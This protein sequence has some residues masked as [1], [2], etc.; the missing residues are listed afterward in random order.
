MPLRVAQTAKLMAGVLALPAVVAA[1][2]L[3]GIEGYRVLRPD[4][5]AFDTEVPLVSLAQAITECCRVEDAYAFISAGQDPNEPIT[6]DDRE[7]TGGGSITVS[8]LMLAVAAGNGS[9][10]QMLISFGA[11]PGLPQNRLLGC[12]AQESGQ[13][14]M[15]TIIA[16][17]AGER[18]QTD[19]PNRSSNDPRPL[20]RWVLDEAAAA[21]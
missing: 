14:E 20:L 13:T 8:P 9:V 12:L 4:S 5:R 19:C 6:I 17:H 7:Y 18:A 21:R 1:V 2:W 10:V 16:T 3:S 11:E 15:L